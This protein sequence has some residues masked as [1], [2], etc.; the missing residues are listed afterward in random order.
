V[1]IYHR[2]CQCSR[3]AGCGLKPYQL[4]GP[5]TVTRQQSVDSEN[6]SLAILSPLSFSAARNNQHGSS[7]FRQV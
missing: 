7:L 4:S 5:H 3:D 1:V 6:D 2:L